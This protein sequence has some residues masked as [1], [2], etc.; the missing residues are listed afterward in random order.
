MEG[1]SRHIDRKKV[2]IGVVILCVA[3]VMMLVGEE[4]PSLVSQILWILLLGIGLLV[5]LWGRFFSGEDP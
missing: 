5:Y 4:N 3:V 1:P 2:Y